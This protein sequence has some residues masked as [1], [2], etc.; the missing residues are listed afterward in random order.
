[1]EKD[2]KHLYNKHNKMEIKYREKIM[3]W[4]LNNQINENILKK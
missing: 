3:Q 2:L 1:M 4:K